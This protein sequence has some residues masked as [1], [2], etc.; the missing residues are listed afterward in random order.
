MSNETKKHVSDVVI[1]GGLIG[2]V[3]AFC[4]YTVLTQMSADINKVQQTP[5]TINTYGTNGE[6]SGLEGQ[7]SEFTGNFVVQPR[8][9]N[10]RT[11]LQLR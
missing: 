8:D 9:V 3:L 4:V 11:D 6:L 10:Q 1:F 7:S 5:Y 2:T